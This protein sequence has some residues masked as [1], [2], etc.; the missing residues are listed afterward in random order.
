[1]HFKHNSKNKLFMFRLILL[2][3]FFL[4]TCEVLVRVSAQQINSSII[5]CLSNLAFVASTK[6][7]SIILLQAL[8]WFLDNKQYACIG[9]VVVGFMKKKTFK[10]F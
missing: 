8:F 3:S 5:I 2:S 4:Y 7:H 6:K 9:I 1:M 10:H